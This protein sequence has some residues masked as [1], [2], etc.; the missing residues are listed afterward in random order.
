MRMKF[1]EAVD[2]LVEVLPARLAS[3]MLVIR[4]HRRAA[5]RAEPPAAPAGRPALGATAVIDEDLGESV[6]QAAAQLHVARR[7]L[8]RR[9]RVRVRERHRPAAL[10]AEHAEI[11]L[12]LRPLRTG[13]VLNARNRLLG[14]ATAARVV[15]MVDLAG[16][17][18]AD[19]SRSTS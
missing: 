15:P 6:V 8:E 3:D 19:P 1:D 18:W 2:E 11:L 12:S 14:E 4:L 5:A 9:P 10:R 16:Q 7:A 13:E 17:R